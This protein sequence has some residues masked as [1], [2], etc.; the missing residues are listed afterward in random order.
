M[1]LMVP[2]ETSAVT[3]Y[4]KLMLSRRGPVGVER[5]DRLERVSRSSYSRRPIQAAAETAGTLLSWGSREGCFRNALKSVSCD[6]E[7]FTRM[8]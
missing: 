3:S 6:I 5:A 2:P 4:Q 7:W 8:P 1:H